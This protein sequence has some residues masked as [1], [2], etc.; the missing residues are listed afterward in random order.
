LY[1]TLAQKANLGKVPWSSSLQTVVGSVRPTAGEIFYEG[2]LL[3]A[4]GTAEPVRR[5]VAPVL[6]ARRLFARMTVYETLR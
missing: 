1:E 2:R 6:E 3:A 4:I 5:D